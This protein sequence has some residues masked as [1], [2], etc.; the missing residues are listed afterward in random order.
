[1]RTIW[2]GAKLE[3]ESV[4]RETCDKVLNDATVTEKKRYMRSVGL[5]IMGE[6]S[7]APMYDLMSAV[8]LSSF[9]DQAFVAQPKEGEEMEKVEE[10]PKAPPPPPVHYNYPQDKTPATHTSSATRGP[11]NQSQP[12]LPPRPTQ[13]PEKTKSTPQSSAPSQGSQSAQGPPT[14]PQRHEPS[15][16]SSGT[17]AAL[18]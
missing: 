13:A 6:V 1:M 8:D 10:Q 4:I 17:H 12:P 16:K 5:K 11:S 14:L 7:I 18:P 3:V 9:G 15:A 2:K